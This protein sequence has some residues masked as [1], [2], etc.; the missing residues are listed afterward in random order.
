[1][2]HRT[3]QLPSSSYSFLFLFPL[4]PLWGGHTELPRCPFKSAGLIVKGYHEKKAR[5]LGT[6]ADGFGKA[7]ALPEPM[8]P[9]RNSLLAHLR[10][11]QIYKSEF[12]CSSLGLLK[13]DISVPE[14]T[15][16]LSASITFLRLS[17]LPFPP[18]QMLTLRI[19]PNKAPETGLQSGYQGAHPGMPCLFVPLALLFPA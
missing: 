10:R 4:S 2:G 17:L 15:T 1:M 5:T 8:L 13:R 12:S 6:F 18:S 19:L 7:T 11:L 16:E 3:R 9:S 14:F